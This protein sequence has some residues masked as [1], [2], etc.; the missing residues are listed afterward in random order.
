M[1]G[2]V[3]GIGAPAG[4]RPKASKMLAVQQRSR[5]HRLRR[6]TSIKTVE[7]IVDLLPETSWHLVSHF[8][9][10]LA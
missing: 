10:R 3:I 8:Q 4:C 2:T 6:P 9:S 1:R 5:R 7:Q